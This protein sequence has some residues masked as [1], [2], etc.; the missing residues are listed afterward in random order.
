MA[1]RIALPD[2]KEDKP[3]AKPEVP[4]PFVHLRVHSSFSLT[5]GAIK[6]KDLV[7]LC[8]KKQM[9][10]VAVTD[11]NNMFGAL[12]FAMAAADSGVQPIMALQLDLARPDLVAGAPVGRDQRA[13]APIALYAR[14]KAGFQN[15]AN[16]TSQA[17]FQSE[18]SARLTLDE[19]KGQT[20]GLI[21]L[22]G[23]PCGILGKLLQA[24]QRAIAETVLDQLETMFPNALYI[25]LQRHESDGP[26]APE[27]ATEA[28]FLEWAET[29]ALPLVATNEAYFATRDMYDAHDAL[30]CIA[31]GR[32]VVETDRRRLTPDHYFKSGAEMAALF[33]DVPEAIANT[34]V[35]AKRCAFMPMKIDPL[36]PTYPDLQSGVTAEAEMIRQAKDGLRARLAKLTYEYDPKIYADRLDYELGVINSMGFAGYFLICADFIKWAKAHNIPVGPGRGSGAGSVVAWALTITDL[37]PFRFGLLFERFL[38]PERVSMPDF[39][40]DFCQ[41]RRDE[42]IRYVMQRYGADRVAQIITF[43]QLKARAVLRDVGRVLQLPYPV[44]DRLCKLIPN[45]PTA[46]VTL[47]EAIDADP[48]LEAARDGDEQ[49]AR[50]FEIAMQLEGLNRNASTH[51]AG[52]VISDRPL[53]QLVPLYRDPDS[54]MPVTQYNMKMVELA[55]LVKFDFLGLKTLTVLQITVDLLRLRGIEVDLNNLPLDDEASY[56]LLARGDTTAVF[57]FESTG[58]R[59]MLRKLGPD[60]FEDII[61]LG[62]LYRP[63][64]MDN[65]PSFIARKH[66]REVVEYPHPKVEAVLKETYGIPVYQEQVMEM[67]RVLAGYSLGGADLLRRAMGKKIKSE[68]D[69]QR[70]NFVAG[71][72]EHSQIDEKTANS[73]FALIEKFAG[74]GFNKSHAAAYALIAY[75]TAYL[76][77]NHPYEFL[78]AS[79]TYDMGTVEKLA[80]FRDELQRAGI[81]VLPPDI[82]KSCPV[83]AVE[84]LVEGKRAIRYALAAIKGVGR[85]AM[86]ALV[87]ERQANGTFKDLRDLLLRCDSRVINKKQLEQLV[88]AGAFDSLHKDG[89]HGRAELMANMDR[90]LKFGAQAAG[91]RDTGQENLFAAAPAENKLV[92]QETKPWDPLT[93]L[94]HEASAVGFYLSAHPLDSYRA[95]LERLDVVPSTDIQNR[96]KPSGGNLIKLAGIPVEFRERTSQKGSRYAFAKLTDNAGSFEVMVFSDLLAVAREALQQNTPL[97]CYVSIQMREG[98]MRL[99]LQRLEAIDVVLAREGQGLR[100]QLAEPTAATQMA[101]ILKTFR[102]GKGKLTLAMPVREDHMAEIALPGGYSLSLAERQQLERIA[103]VVSVEMA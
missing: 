10:A 87:A 94:T 98:E 82:N 74:Y 51:A 81:Q 59:D 4:V 42:V 101:E 7:K 95:L 37:D 71:C 57:Q 8:V 53:T 92:L 39:D 68:M 40:I 31:A 93:Q 11:T 43:G 5:E 63:G 27:A 22:T 70:A 32:Y 21:C 60:V 36:L 56:K 33:A 6:P 65:I 26:W 78:A 1:R 66:G 18:G 15:L 23:G 19:L 76:K 97:I 83:F 29:R 47:Q 55:G 61:A 17:F 2:L 34:L 102:A 89:Q 28:T 99:T 48:V 84:E 79:M 80:Q 20:E 25:E 52:V 45:N 41:D 100:I 13:E 46:P 75:Q 91:E 72:A 88:Q 69:A 103:G 12:E 16:L 30:L 96:Y 9:P 50:L 86:E 73:I 62:A 3:P 49:I 58:M 67:A 64:P 44:I 14:N 35:I 90:I 24:G 77:A 38:N 85:A 54:D